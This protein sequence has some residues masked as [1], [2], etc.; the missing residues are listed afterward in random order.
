MP[1]SVFANGKTLRRF[2]TLYDLWWRNLFI[3]ITS[4]RLDKVFTAINKKT[5]NDIRILKIIFINFYYF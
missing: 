3:N 1:V 2:E 4:V 5:Y